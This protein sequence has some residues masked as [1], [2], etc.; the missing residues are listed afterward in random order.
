M[1]KVLL[2]STA[3]IPDVPTPQAP[4]KPNKVVEQARSAARPREGAARRRRPSRGARRDTGGDE[5]ADGGED[6][7]DADKG[8]SD[9]EPDSLVPDPQVC[10]EFG[11]SAMTLWR[12][13]RDPDLNF[14]ARIAIGRRNYRSRKKIEKFKA[15]LLR[16]AIAQRAREARG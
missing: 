6:D 8:G 16:R 10:R 3:A 4:E 5:D 12:W 14:P 9:G 1:R 13:D 2:G 7:E 15:R 11:V